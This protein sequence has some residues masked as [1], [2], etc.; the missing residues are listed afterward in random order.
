M[1]E[2]EKDFFS[3]FRELMI[4][5]LKE[6]YIDGTHQGAI[7]TCAI[8]YKTMKIAGLEEDNF[9]FYML[10]DLAEKHGCKDLE[11]TI[12]QIGNKAS[13]SRDEILS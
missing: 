7:S 2:N 12:E 11:A 9:L 4:E 5:Q 3:D 13:L 8:I 6:A 1:S 10:K